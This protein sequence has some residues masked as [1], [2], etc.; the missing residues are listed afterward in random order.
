MPDYWLATRLPHCVHPITLIRD[1]LR[2]NYSAYMRAFALLRPDRQGAAQ[3]GDPP[4]H[5][6]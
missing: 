5:D 3:F 4:L 1:R 2:R 6:A